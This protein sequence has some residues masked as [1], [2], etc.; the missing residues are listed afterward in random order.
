MAS[1]VSSSPGAGMVE[2][3]PEDIRLQ[4]DDV[5]RRIWPA[6]Q[7]H[8]TGEETGVSFRLHALLI[9]AVNSDSTFTPHHHYVFSKSLKLLRSQLDGIQV[10]PLLVLL[11]EGQV[12]SSTES[13]V[14][15][16]LVEELEAVERAQKRE[17]ES[18]A[19]KRSTDD[20][21]EIKSSDKSS[22]SSMP[23]RV[24]TE[25]PDATVAENSH[26]NN[27]EGFK[28]FFENIAN[29]GVHRTIAAAAVSCIAS[30]IGTGIGT[31]ILDRARGLQRL[32]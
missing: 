31:Y 13:P 3:F 6:W 24:G 15:Q 16:E 5:M 19:D 25:E 9:Q 32:E 23:T 22:H 26:R 28:G 17:K 27:V 21:E 29:L 11:D 14:F 30:R 12:Y 4:Y 10:Q 18:E 8:E 1:T 2:S 7:R 20:D